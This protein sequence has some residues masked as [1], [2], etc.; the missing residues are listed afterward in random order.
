MDVEL[1]KSKLNYYE[2]VLNDM[3]RISKIF[4]AAGI[5]AAMVFSQGQA[6]AMTVTG[7]SQ[8]MTVAD[9]TV[10]ATDQ[11][12]QKIKFVS[13]GH[14]MHL[15]SADGVKDFLSFNSFDGRTDGVDFNVRAIE[16]TDPG[17]RLLEI[18]A[19]RGA[20][21]KNC[22]YWLVG[23]HNGLW[24]AYVSWNSLSNIGFRVDR[25]H[26]LSS[27]IVDQQLVVTSHDGY[28][29][30]DFQTQVFWDSDCQWFGL[31]RF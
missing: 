15:M 21:A 4:A 14:V 11:D 26:S 10:T 8:G 12:G 20:H 29:N 7:I 6:D 17:M 23:K 30:V 5:A 19:T 28:G 25:W 3:N 1:L 27:S 18:T 2:G 24:T 31:R 22:G 16:T 9:K 13:D